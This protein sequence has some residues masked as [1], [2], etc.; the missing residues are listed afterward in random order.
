MPWLLTKVD[1]VSDLLGMDLGLDAAQHPVG[2]FSLDLKR[3]N[4]S[5]GETVI[6]ERISW[7]SLIGR[8]GLWPHHCGRR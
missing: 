6:V 8:Q 7:K 5:M 2:G 3:Y 4:E 1:V